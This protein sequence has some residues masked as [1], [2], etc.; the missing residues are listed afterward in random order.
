MTSR[1]GG[2]WGGGVPISGSVDDARVRGLCV[3]RG[4][5]P[6]A[7]LMGDAGGQRDLSPRPPPIRTAGTIEAEG[8]RI[9][10]P[11]PPQIPF[12]SS[13]SPSSPILLP[14]LP[15]PTNLL[16]TSA[17]LPLFPASAYNV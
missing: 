3:L 15:P 14:L 13:Y 11:Q 12:Q 17:P 1:S 8:L 4:N 10:Q 9:S 16:Y 2:G 6:T 5:Q 7:E